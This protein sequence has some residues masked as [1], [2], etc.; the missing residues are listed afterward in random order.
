MLVATQLGVDPVP[1]H[2]TATSKQTAPYA[3]DPRT[4]RNTTYKYYCDR[5]YTWFMVIVMQSVTTVISY[6]P[7]NL[8][9]IYVFA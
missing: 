2:L 4:H 7:A 1:S 3:V 6:H 5:F 9:E 8:I